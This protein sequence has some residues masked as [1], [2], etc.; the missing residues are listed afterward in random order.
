M[1]FWNTFNRIVVVIDA[2]V[3]MVSLTVLF[4]IP[5]I[6][7]R[8]FG[9]WMMGWGRYFGTVT[10]WVRIILGIL[11]AAVID[12][13]LGILIFLEVRPT[14]K[15]F[16]RVQQVSGGMANISTESVT[17]LLQHKLDPEP[18]VIQVS[19]H[20]KAKGNRVAAT[21]DVGVIPTANV[22]ETAGRLI[23]ITQTVL[24]DELGLRIAGQPEVRVTV[25]GE[26]APERRKPPERPSREAI[27]RET[28]SAPPPLPGGPSEE[29]EEDKGE[30]EKGEEQ[31]ESAAA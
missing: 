20:V 15:R 17:Q 19:P 21:V 12:L 26:A 2:L 24:T 13:L 4:L 8:D 6:I 10:P 31:K 27:F 14:R 28:P 22:P 29:E 18:G 7:L 16:I 5:Q 23:R 25:V 30:E 3:L 1:K 9:E 11:F